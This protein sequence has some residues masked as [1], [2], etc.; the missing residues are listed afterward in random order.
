MLYVFKTVGKKLKYSP[1][2]EGASSRLMKNSAAGNFGD[3][4][5]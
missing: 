3:T 4:I 5:L 2:I 1:K